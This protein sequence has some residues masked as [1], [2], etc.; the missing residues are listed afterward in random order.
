MGATTTELET[1]EQQFIELI[2]EYQTLS[3]SEKQLRAEFRREAARAE[4][5]E[6]ARD[7][8]ERSAAD[9]RATAAAATAGAAQA[10][11]ALA[12]A[13]E[14]L[15]AVKMQLEISENQRKLFEEK[16]TEMSDKM[17]CL[18]RELQQLQPL[19][20]AYGTI[21]RQYVELQGRI[22][23]ATEEARSEV[24][25]LEV[26]LRRV[27]RCAGAGAELRERARL[28]AAAHARE[29]ALAADE[30]AHTTRE[31]QT[32]N[33][34]IARLR[35]KVTE[36]QYQ[37]SNEESVKKIHDPECESL[38]EVRAALEAE[39]SGTA[40]LE[41]ALAA[42]LA[43]NAALASELHSKDNNSVDKKTPLLN[44]ASSNICPIDLFLAE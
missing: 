24:S 2:S 6:A 22:Q 20:C 21:Q 8:A 33:A 15:V 17:S 36:L 41:R 19:Q 39:R 10:A 12:L 44:N 38:V 34:E 4:G 37:L 29:R 5:A 43:D 9:S 25:K 13:Q 27:E 40:K 7:A 1:F 14:E 3:A 30:L 26:E 18:E 42:A 11:K 28:A 16:C 32:A 31:L 35:I 23:I